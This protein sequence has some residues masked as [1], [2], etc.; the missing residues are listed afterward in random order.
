M[1]HKD[2]RSSHVTRRRRGEGR[3]PSH[4]LRRADDNN[5]PHIEAAL[6]SGLKETFPAS[7]PVS[8]STD[9]D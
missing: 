1:T 6:D 9:R 7:D 5:D 4:P 2:E 3:P 8:I